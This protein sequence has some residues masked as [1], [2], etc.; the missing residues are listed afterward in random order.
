[1]CIRLTSRVNAPLSISLDPP[2]LVEASSQLILAGPPL[3]AVLAGAVPHLTASF[4]PHPP[5][6]ARSHQSVAH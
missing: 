3:A 4:T 2:F 5:K 1:M 6:L